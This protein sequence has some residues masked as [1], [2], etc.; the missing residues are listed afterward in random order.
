MITDDTILY[1]RENDNHYTVKGYMRL[2]EKRKSSLWYKLIP[3]EQKPFCCEIK[4][5]EED[6]KNY[7]RREVI[8]IK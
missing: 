5:A 4:M 7:I 1:I 3:I 2:G 8:T 6:L